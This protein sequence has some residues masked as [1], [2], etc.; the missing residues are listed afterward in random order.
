MKE[1][2]RPPLGIKILGGINFFVLGIFFI[3]LSIFF[4]T[5][6]FQSEELFNTFREEMG[7]KL[8]PQQFK[9]SIFFQLFISIIFAISG[10]GLLLR[11]EWARKLTIYF[12]FVLFLLIFLSILFNPSLIKHSFPQIIYSGILIFYFTNR[13]IEEY[14]KK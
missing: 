8:T 3:I 10:I 2:E 14:F 1:K 5:P 6:S 13:K 7:L 9:I 4:L 12:S 11:K